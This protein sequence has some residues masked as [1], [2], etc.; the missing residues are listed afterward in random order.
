M[1][2]EKIAEE[3]IKEAEKKAASII[4]SGVSDKEKILDEARKRAALRKA[5]M[6]N[7]MDEFVTGLR[8]RELTK[9]KLAIK[10]RAQD[11][12]NEILNSVYK[13]FTEELLK[14][15]KSL[16]KKLMEMSKGFDA[17]T[18]YV[19]K[20][21]YKVAKE[22]FSNVAVS[23]SDISGG[24]ILENAGS[25]ETIDMRLERIGQLARD[26]TIKDVSRILFGGK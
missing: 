25:R 15:R 5:E 24:I 12:R 3:I 1:E 26:A 20:E 11:T 18:V 10:K 4:D 21:D 14:D 19:N 2:M 6:K 13:K 9:A 17:K 7:N 8:T 23:E 16:I 22:L